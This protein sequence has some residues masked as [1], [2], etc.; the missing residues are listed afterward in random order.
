ME[1]RILDEA[2]R[3]SLQGYVPF[4]VDSTADFTPDQFKAV[5]DE[6]LRP[7]F[8]V[9]SFKQSE[10]Q[11]LKK[12]NARNDTEKPES[13]NSIS[14]ANLQIVRGCV[15]GWI[16]L[17]DAGTG[18]EIDFRAEAT[19]GCDKGLWASFP[20][21][22]IRELMDYVRKISGLTSVDELGLK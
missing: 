13:I 17:F 8:S 2:T 20:V 6:T 15:V 22:L 18:G 12:N 21:W 4:S 5:K 7:I 14:E 10:M 16:N 1:K 9:R 3:K 11:E 19:G